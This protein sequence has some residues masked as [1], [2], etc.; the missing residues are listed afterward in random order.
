MF[1]QEI[2]DKNGIKNKQETNDLLRVACINEGKAE[3]NMLPPMNGRIIINTPQ[4]SHPV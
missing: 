2:N 1:L 4:V 3:K